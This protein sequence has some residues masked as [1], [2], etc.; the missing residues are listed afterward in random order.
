MVSFAFN[1]RLHFKLFAFVSVLC[2]M[3]SGVFAQ[4]ITVKGVIFKK[5]TNDRISQALVNDLNNKVIMMSDELGM[6]SISASVGDTLVISKSNYTP[7]RITVLNKDDLA[8][9]LQPVIELNQVTI[10]GETKKQELTDVMKQ[11]KSQGVFNDG[12]S[13][14]FWE[15]VNSPITGFYNLFG[16]SPGQARRFAEYS[17]TELENTEVDR[18]Y[19]KDLVKSIT[20]LPDDEVVKFM[21]LYTPSYQ[22]IKEW[23]DYKLITY[24]KKNLAYYQ[25]TKNIPQ[26]KLN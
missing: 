9:Y 22:D 20:K 12:K 6:F 14:P 11:Y 8:L 25:K 1:M 2:C 21:Q 24:I 19:T 5:S 7:L 23:N 10:K 17:K 15:F 18:R 26:Q 13:L 4:A 16:K 3:C